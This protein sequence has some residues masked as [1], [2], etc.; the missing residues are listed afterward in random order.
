[1]AFGSASLNRSFKH[2]VFSSGLTSSSGGA[3]PAATPA[4]DKATNA[5]KIKEPE[6]WKDF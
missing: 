4:Q 6:D 1:L 5:S 2:I 3:S